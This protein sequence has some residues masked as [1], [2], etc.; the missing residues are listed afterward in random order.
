MLETSILVA[1]SG[2]V[3]FFYLRWTW[4]MRNRAVEQQRK[5]IDAAFAAKVVRSA[6]ASLC[7][8]P[9]TAILIH[10]S[11]TIRGQSAILVQTSRLYRNGPGEYFLFM[12]TAGDPGFIKYLSR[13]EAMRMLKPYRKA[14]QAELGRL[15]VNHERAE[16]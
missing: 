8:D 12:C 1:A 16:P 5:T 2:V 4:R 11:E 9:S 6:N 3:G 10:E 7:F 15:S 14:Y 13:I